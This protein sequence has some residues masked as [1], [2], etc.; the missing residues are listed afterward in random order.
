MRDKEPEDEVSIPITRTVVIMALV[1]IAM[2]MVY[3]LVS[4]ILLGN[5][6]DSMTRYTRALEI[7]MMHEFYPRG[8]D[9][10]N[11][12]GI[13]ENMTIAKAREEYFK[14]EGYARPLAQQFIDYVCDGRK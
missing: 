11:R 4:G 1:L 13:N 5:R 6:N 10:T 2:F 8:V 9:A 14:Y 7:A 3:Y 12:W